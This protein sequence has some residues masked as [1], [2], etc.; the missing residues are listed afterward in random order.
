LG[1]ETDRPWDDFDD[2]VP[3]ACSGDGLNTTAS[4]ETFDP[5]AVDG[6]KFQLT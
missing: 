2:R 1:K 3:Q 6:G 4:R 5:K